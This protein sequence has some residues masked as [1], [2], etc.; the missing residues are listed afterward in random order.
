MK[1]KTRSQAVT[2]RHAWARLA[3]RLVLLVIGGVVWPQLGLSPLFG[4]IPVHAASPL[5]SGF[6][7]FGEGGILRNIS[8]RI[9]LVQRDGKIVTAKRAGEQIQ[10]ARYLTN[11][12]LDPSFG[13]GGLS[14]V[15]FP[16]SFEPAA[17]VEQADGRIVVGGERRDL[18][19][20]VVAVG[21]ILPDGKLDPAFTFIAEEMLLER[22][23]NGLHDLALQADGKI[24]AG[25][26][27]RVCTQGDCGNALFAMRLLKDGGFDTSFNADGVAFIEF[28]ID[29]VSARELVV[30][31]SGHLY[32]VGVYQGISQ[33]ERQALVVRL[34]TDG[35]LDPTYGEGG[36]AIHAGITDR[37]ASHHDALMLTKDRLIIGGHH[38][39]LL[40]LL[41]DGSKDPSFGEGGILTLNGPFGSL[42]FLKLA[43][44]VGG[45]IVAAGLHQPAEG[46]P[47]IVVTVITPAG[48]PDAAFGNG[49]GAVK[50]PGFNRFVSDLHAA[51]DGRLVVEIFLSPD[52]EVTL[53]RLHANGQ[54]DRGG[55]V[56]ANWTQRSATIRDLAVRPD[57]RIDVVGDADDTGHVVARYHYTGVLDTSFGGQGFLGSYTY[58][59]PTFGHAIA[60]DD[61]GNT[62]VVAAIEQDA[63]NLDYIIRRYSPAGAPLNFP[64][65]PTLF[66][67][68]DWGTNTDW[69]IAIHVLPDG[70]FI[71]AGTARNVFAVTRYLANGQRDMSFGVGQ[72]TMYLDMPGAVDFANDM[73]VQ[74]DGKILL[75]GQS[76]DQLALARLDEQGALDTSFN[77]SGFILRDLPD[78]PGEMIT[79]IVIQPDGKIVVSVEASVPDFVTFMVLRFN[80]DGTP[81][82]GFGDVGVATAHF[83][84]HADPMALALDT[85]GSIMVAGCVGNKLAVVRL[86]P[87]GSLDRAFGREGAYVMDEMPTTGRACASVIA[88]DA[89]SDNFVLGGKALT[90]SS[91]THPSPRA[92]WVL[93]RVD[94][95]E[96]LNQL[97]QAMPDSFNAQQDTVLSV[98]APGLLANDADP[99][100][101]ALTAHL[102]QVPQHGSALVQPDGSFTYTPT[103]DFVGVDHFTY[104]ASD[105]IDNSLPTTVTITVEAAPA[106][107]TQPVAQPNQYATVQDQPLTI[108]V[109]GVL[110]GDTDADDDPLVAVLN[111][112]PSRGT[113]QLNGDGSFIYTPA[114]GFVGED[115]FTYRASDGTLTSEP[116][117]VTLVITALATNA[118]PTAVGN[119]YSTQRDMLLTVNAPGVLEN[120]SD[121]NGDP[122]TAELVDA[123]AS[124]I[125]TLNADGSFSYTPNPGFV[126]KAS[127]T[128]RVSDG[129]LASAPAIVTLDVI[130]VTTNVPPSAADDAYS[131]RHDT[132]LSMDAPGVLDNDSDANDDA[133]TAELADAPTNGTLSLQA[134]G[135][136]TYLPNIGFVGLDSFTYRLLDGTHLSETAKVMIEVMEETV[137]AQQVYLPM[138][139]DQ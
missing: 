121:A 35:S 80:A 24:V 105:G 58:P 111:T 46:E 56:T 62:L 133:L 17:L 10:F 15:T 76:G 118:A 53:L 93:A 44:H 71:V 131:V 139:V 21:R 85:D 27:S 31:S 115:S 59:K 37:T 134:D 23:G 1:F 12:T 50:I 26:A 38:D 124:G 48:E 130:A 5:T 45:G 81:D 73:A 91:I 117:T 47:Y 32:L 107:N 109:P 74:S 83:S 40:A 9:S 33:T 129:A 49:I 113:L 69:P 19:P 30:A 68:T 61:D 125:L 122:L 79:S 22:I 90:M 14:M 88:Y 13:D 97:P 102:A 114:A 98:N 16:V 55:W 84:E 4:P 8:G 87:D 110:D 82:A 52:D 103:T 94:G 51:H 43:P 119:A 41:P 95:K 70:K 89:N 39:T 138:I 67:V 64:Q 132:L 11:G 100:G 86:R 36:K 108:A 116:A 60:L 77:T 135:S 101:H 57:G 54:L 106:D 123:P 75:A 65:T 2:R 78:L 34:Q 72:G 66:P 137:S 128:Y 127:F 126:G 96:S 112:L 7:E 136:F 28:G 120:D 29:T 92:Q 25:G 99:D 20:I 3:L 104:Y 6:N 42:R 63:G 18:Q